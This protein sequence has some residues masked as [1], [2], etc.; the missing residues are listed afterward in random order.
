MSLKNIIFTN[1][2]EMKKANYGTIKINP[3]MNKFEKQL[4]FLRVSIQISK[5]KKVF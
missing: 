4:I 1:W 3:E 5:S 2:I